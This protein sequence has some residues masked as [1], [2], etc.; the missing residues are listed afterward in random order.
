MEAQFQ[1]D[2]VPSV[3]AVI[4]MVDVS[5]ESYLQTLASEPKL[6]TLTRFETPSGAS[7]WARLWD[8]TV[9]RTGP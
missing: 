4:E 3:Q 1:P 6:P 8:L 9:S 2:T 7:R 5:L